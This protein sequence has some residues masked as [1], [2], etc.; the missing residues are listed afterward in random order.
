MCARIPEL[1]RRQRHQG[2]NAYP[3]EDAAKEL[4]L[5]GREVALQGNQFN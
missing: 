5:L 3:K 4:T 1:Q 2:G